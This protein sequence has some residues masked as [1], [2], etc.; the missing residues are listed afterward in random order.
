[1]KRL[2]F[3]DGL[4][5]PAFSAIKSLRFWEL[6]L[7]SL[8]VPG[9]VRFPGPRP[10]PALIA[11][12]GPRPPHFIIG[13]SRH[14]VTS[15]FDAMD[16]IRFPTNAAPQ[17]NSRFVGEDDEMRTKFR[18]PPM[19]NQRVP[20]TRLSGSLSASWRFRQRLTFDRAMVDS[21]RRSEA[22]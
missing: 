8:L 19:L 13:T 15:G 22:A 3:V 2:V 10:V 7:L 18:F 4:L 17:P 1:V 11:L 6:G 5:F 9:E 21:I 12:C 16:P 14:P 20:T